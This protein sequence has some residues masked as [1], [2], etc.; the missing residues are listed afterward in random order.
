LLKNFSRTTELYD[1]AKKLQLESNSYNFYKYLTAN[2]VFKDMMFF[3]QTWRQVKGY[4][5]NNQR[6]HSNNKNNKKKK[7]LNTYRLQ[8]FYK[9]FGRKR[10][11]IFPTLII[12]EYTNRLW[13]LIWY[14]EWYQAWIFIVHLAQKNRKI[15]KFDPQLLS[16]NIITGVRKIKKKKKH[17]ASKKKIIL[18]ATIGLPVLFSMYIYNYKNKY[19][20][21]FK[22]TISED[23]RKKMGKKKK[24]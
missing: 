3:T 10:R 19:D 1:E 2:L 14:A 23:S 21:P 7:L 16:K 24:K 13:Y 5:K 15:V 20:L 12:A 8:Q 22:L 4:S 17:N 11:D 18:V 9:L 6:T